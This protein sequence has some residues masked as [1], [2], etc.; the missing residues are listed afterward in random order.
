MSNQSLLSIAVAAMLSASFA[1][2]PAV[3]VAQ[4]KSVP[5]SQRAVDMIAVKDGS[6][7]YGMQ[8]P[9]SK[10][11]SVAIVVQRSWLGKELPDELKRIEA[12]EA[13]RTKE[14]QGEIIRR[15]DAWIAARKGDV[16]LI[17]FLESERDRL[18]EDPDDQLRVEPS[19]FV[20]LE[21]PERNL[22]RNYKQTNERKTIGLLALR[23]RLANVETRSAD[24]LKAELLKLNR[25][26][27][28]LPVNLRDRMPAGPWDPSAWDAE[29]ALAE[30][31]YRKPLE[32]QS[33]GGTLIEGGDD[34]RPTDLSQIAGGLLQSQLGDLLGEGGG[35]RP[36]NSA[37]DLA[38]QAQKRA[39]AAG[40]KGFR[41]NELQLDATRGSASVRS[42]FYA[43]LG[44]GRWQ[45]VW[46]TSENGANSEAQEGQKERIAQD[47]TVK[48]AFDLA[49]QLGVDESAIETSLGV[50][51]ATQT[52]LRRANSNFFEFRDRNLRQLGDSW[53]P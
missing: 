51:A 53:K 46:S 8:T 1:V 40:V 9:A 52:A 47:P 19:Q 31:Q 27:L 37:A 17:S 25:D 29:V 3:V 50:G 33:F 16:Q 18:S 44:N 43:K 45:S 39:E 11:R 41:I 32:F 24:D 38:K 35:K 22:R 6:A 4:G 21:Y 5:V 48:Q 42:A 12:E 20:L 7:Y 15:L 14:S 13:A 36:G 34:A 49:K 23:N 30:F 26:Q 28:Q 10:P 2:S